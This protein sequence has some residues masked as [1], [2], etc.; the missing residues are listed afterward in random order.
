MICEPCVMINK[1]N[2]RKMES[3]T[4]KVCTR[5]R[6]RRRGNTASSALDNKSDDVLDDTS[7]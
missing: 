2:G 5:L 1:L 6:V 3:I 4:H 7:G